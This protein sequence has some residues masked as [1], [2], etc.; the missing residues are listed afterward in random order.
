MTVTTDCDVNAL[1]TWRA[2]VRVLENEIPRP[3]FDSW[4][5]TAA[6]L[7][8]DGDM[9]TLGVTSDF[10]G[11]VIKTK[12][13]GL[14]RDCL[15][16]QLGRDVDLAIEV[17]QDPNVLVKMGYLSEEEQAADKLARQVKAREQRLLAEGGFSS[18]MMKEAT[19]D[20]YRFY[21]EQQR[22]VVHVCR[23]YEEHF[24]N[25]PRDLMLHGP[26]GC[27]KSKAV[28]ATCRR[29]AVAGPYKVIYASC[30]ELDRI[31]RERRGFEQEVL[32][33]DLFAP[34]DID[35]GLGGRA[36]DLTKAFLLRLLEHRDREKTP[37]LISSTRYPLEVHQSK[38]KDDVAGRLTKT[39]HWEESDGP[40]IRTVEEPEDEL[41][42]W[43][44]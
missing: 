25:V 4:L 26:T 18:E 36:T 41:K 27:G 9:F 35:K 6:P 30:W 21:T 5:R 40:N 20:D 12:Y 13:S 39:F 31:L 2:V 32:H 14:I 42:W 17:M 22:R 44:Q 43:A 3:T 16:K 28:R 10:A 38:L 1:D 33:C 7:R 29:I 24:P 19:F 34:D 23:K 11:S 37:H 8:I 15:K